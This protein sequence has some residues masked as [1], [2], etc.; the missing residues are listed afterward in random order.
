MGPMNDAINPVKMYAYALLGKQMVGM[1]VQELSLR[2]EVVLTAKTPEEFAKC[3]AKVIELKD[4]DETRR[5]LTTF[6]QQNTWEHR[7]DEAWKHLLPL[8]A[9]GAIV[10]R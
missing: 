9:S 2:P 5:R 3:V 8:L 4:D 7:A 6:A 1:A 10:G